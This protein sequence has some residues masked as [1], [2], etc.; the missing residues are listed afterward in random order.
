MRSF[1]DV[2]N[3]AL[4][5]PC[6]CLPV[7]DPPAKVVHARRAAAVGKAARESGR[8]AVFTNGCF[9]LLHEGH[10]ATLEAARQLGDLLI[11]AVNTDASVRAIKGAGRPVQCQHIRAAQLGDTISPV[12]CWFGLRLSRN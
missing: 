12:S 11:V 2:W 3:G 9:D 1:D 8:T 5:P 6:A 4:S 10:L 7:P